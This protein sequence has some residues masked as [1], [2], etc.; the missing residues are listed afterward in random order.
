[1]KRPLALAALAV[2]MISGSAQADDPLLLS[3]DATTPLSMSAGDTLLVTGVILSSASGA[4][5]EPTAAF[6][7]EAGG[8][9]VAPVAERDHRPGVVQ[10]RAS[11]RPG[12]GCAA[13]AI[14]SPC[15]VPRLS[16]Y[17][18]QRFMTRAD[19]RRTLSGS[20]TLEM[21]HATPPTA[22]PVAQESYAAPVVGLGAL[23]ASAAAIFAR[24]RRRKRTPIGDVYA[25]A[26]TARKA[27]RGDLTLAVVR[28]QIDELV[29]RAEMLEAAR[30]ESRKR[31]AAIDRT[32][33]ERKREAWSRSSSPDAPEAVEWV[34]AELAEAAR[35]ESDLAS[36][37]AGIERIGAALRVLALRSRQHRGTRAR[38]STGDPVD[39]LASELDRRDAALREASHI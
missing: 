32:A 39:A 12:T 20:W 19:F 29:A 17:A 7:L 10:F 15:L 11:G 14:A 31:L 25:A 22:P 4:Q 24:L 6:D 26:L 2:A 8:L 1:M 16:E 5:L 23:A 9:E 13:A 27:T 33:L 35:L 3:L 37:L 21:L 34:T 36:S 18:H 28:T 38:A 30:I